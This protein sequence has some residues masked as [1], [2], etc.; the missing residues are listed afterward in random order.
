MYTWIGLK[1]KFFFGKYDI[2]IG[3]EIQNITFKNDNFFYNDN[4]EP[5]NGLMQVTIL[6]PRNLFYAFLP[7]KL[8]M[9]ELFFTVEHSTRN[10]YLPPHPH[11][12]PHPVKIS[13]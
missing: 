10:Q 6:P 9:R 12:H 7:I 8:K 3:N 2:L 11:P 4:P 1:Y 13:N 5:L